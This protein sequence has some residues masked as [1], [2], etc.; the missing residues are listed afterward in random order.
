M[1]ECGGAGHIR[2][3]DAGGRAAHGCDP[4]SRPDYFFFASF[5][6]FFVSFFLALLPL[7]MRFLLL[8][9]EVFFAPPRFGAAAGTTGFAVLIS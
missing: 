2:S 9:Y 7:A 5:L 3:I 8:S 4:G 6:G 1:P